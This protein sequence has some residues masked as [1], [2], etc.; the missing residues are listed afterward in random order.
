MHLQNIYNKYGHKQ[1]RF[2]IICNCYMCDLD[3]LE[4]FYLEELKP[5]CN[6]VLDVLN[7]QDKIKVPKMTI[8]PSDMPGLETNWS[9]KNWHK[10]VYGCGR[11]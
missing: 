5:E 4:Q 1:L 7:S 8:P 9:P 6:V 2:E 3:G 11:K 10:W